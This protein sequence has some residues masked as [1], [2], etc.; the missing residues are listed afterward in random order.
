[1]SFNLQSSLGTSPPPPTASPQPDEHP[2]LDS[3]EAVSRPGQATEPARAV[4][5]SSAVEGDEAVD[6][7]SGET[8]AAPAMGAIEGALPAH[9]QLDLQDHPLTSED[10]D[11]AVGAKET[12]EDKSSRPG[13]PSPA[14]TVTSK[15][16]LEITTALYDGLARFPHVGVAKKYT[17]A[18]SPRAGRST[19]LSEYIRRQTGQLRPSTEVTVHLAVALARRSKSDPKLAWL[20][21]G[22][23]WIDKRDSNRDWEAELGE[24]LHPETKAAAVAAQAEARE[25]RRVYRA[26]A[27]TRKRAAAESTSASDESEPSSPSSSR[28]SSPHFPQKQFRASSRSQQEQ[29]STVFPPPYPP[30]FFSTST[31]QAYFPQTY[32]PTPPAIFSPITAPSP[33]PN[34]LTARHVQALLSSAFPSH[35]FSSAAVAF[36]S[37]GLST[38]DNIHRLLVLEDFLVEPLVDTVI[39]CARLSGLEAGWARK[40]L[41]R[42]RASFAAETG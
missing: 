17:L 26:T 20:L 30:H 35:D 24:D 12:E 33:R 22:N 19:L 23:K 29:A 34:S 5:E 31:S 37:A 11:A 13:M 18:G 3:L 42:L 14:D 2:P 9:H 27:G 15:W 36:S 8:S 10:G 6:E 4:D 41:A 21:T 7:A 1:M 25:A 28:P 40:A 32:F 39:K 38:V 16:T